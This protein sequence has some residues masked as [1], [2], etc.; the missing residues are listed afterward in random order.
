MKNFNKIKESSHFQYLDT[1]N[2][3]GWAMVQTLPVNGF[4]WKENV[5]KFDEKFTKN[6]DQYSNKEYIPEVDVEYPKD[7]H[8]FHSNLP[9]S[10]ERM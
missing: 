1:Y 2:L 7:L 4:R 5:S 10:S 6:Y 8:N 9:F 3:H